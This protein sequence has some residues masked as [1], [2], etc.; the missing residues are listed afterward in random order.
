MDNVTVVASNKSPQPLA[1]SAL[2]R[3]VTLTVPPSH[4]IADS[5]A[6]SIF[7]MAGT[8]MDNVRKATDPLTINLP[9]G[10]IVCSTHVCDIVIPGFP[11]VLT[12]HIVPG[13]S[14]ASLMGIRVLCKAGCIVTFTDTTCEV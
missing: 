13:L 3:N 5:G 6:T 4:S 12:G 8:P 2:P 10:G 11:T 7:V 1:A 9:N 14:M